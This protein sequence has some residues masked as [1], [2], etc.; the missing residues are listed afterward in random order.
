MKLLKANKLLDIIFDKLDERISQLEDKTENNVKNFSKI[1]SEVTSIQN[2]LGIQDIKEAYQKSNK[3]ISLVTDFA[4]FAAHSDLLSPDSHLQDYISS[5][6]DDYN[7]YL[8]NN[9]FFI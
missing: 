4:K 8:L 7:K 3:S 1:K 2:A 9:C 5:N 6:K